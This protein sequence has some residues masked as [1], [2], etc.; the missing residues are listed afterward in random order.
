VVHLFLNPASCRERPNLT[1]HILTGAPQ[2]SIS[3]H[4][5]T[6]PLLQPALTQ[7][8]SHR[9]N[10]NTNHNKQCH[11]QLFPSPSPPSPQRAL[12][13]HPLTTSGHLPRAPSLRRRAET[14]AYRLPVLHLRHRCGH[15]WA[16]Q[17]SRTRPARSK[18]TGTTSPAISYQLHARVRVRSPDPP[19]P[20]RPIPTT[21]KRIP[22]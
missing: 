15:L 2:P 1:K 18:T 3:P 20:Y 22:R 4:L 16:H 11:R 9:T 13:P 7:S 21:G 5:T 14:A 10:T 8:L 19:R 6:L 12:T 17:R